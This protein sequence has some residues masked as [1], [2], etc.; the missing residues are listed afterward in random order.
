[1]IS[2]NISLESND[3][4][5]FQT[6]VCQHP[7]GYN[8]Y[9]NHTLPRLCCSAISRDLTAYCYKLVN[10]RST[11]HVVVLFVHRNS[12]FYHLLKF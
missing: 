7:Y 6:H 8:L 9:Y 12:T 11:I 10:T 5:V 1:M 2:D 4:Y 3:Y